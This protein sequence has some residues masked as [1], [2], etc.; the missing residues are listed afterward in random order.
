MTDWRQSASLFAKTTDRG[1]RELFVGRND[2]FEL[3]WNMCDNIRRD[4]ECGPSIVV[5]G[6]PG[7][8]KTAFLHELSKIADSKNT[9]CVSLLT[10]ALNPTD[11][12]REISTSLHKLP[13]KRR[14]LKTVKTEAS[15]GVLKS[16]IEGSTQEN[17]GS[18]P[19]HSP[20]QLWNVLTE[21]KLQRKLRDRVILLL[22]DEAQN[23]PLDSGITRQ[24]VSALQQGDARGLTAM[25]PIYAGLSNLPAV[26]NDL[27][28]SRVSARAM[29]GMELLSDSESLEYVR[30][31]LDSLKAQCRSESFLHWCVSSC[32]G[33]P[34]H[35]F[36]HMRAIAS[37]MLKDNT[38]IVEDLDF[39]TLCQT[40]DED[41]NTYYARRMG[42]L[43]EFRSI[44]RDVVNKAGTAGASRTELA[45]IV[46]TAVPA[47]S[48]EDANLRD[49]LHLEASDNVPIAFINRLVRSG[50]LSGSG[51]NTTTDLRCPIP[52]MVTWLNESVH[53]TVPYSF[54]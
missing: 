17:D 39:T 1:G 20:S 54:N 48:I 47:K 30:L 16:A 49:L 9:V 6:A 41:R 2:L 8:G 18:L 52:S 23:L 53:R 32:D 10:S 28:L 40:L 36:V 22:I 27:G 3:V 24:T 11:I 21:R 45:R 14:W 33:F 25:V 38:N 7:S 50:V 4:P 26:L 34:Q 43:E 37:Q 29:C 19:V 51:E 42:S 5:S 15:I 46:A 13:F 12:H 44:A 31:T 35:L